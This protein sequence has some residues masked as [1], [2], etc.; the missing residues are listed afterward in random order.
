M[1]N[2]LFNICHILY[3]NYLKEQSFKLYFIHVR[4][5]ARTEVFHRFRGCIYSY[6]VIVAMSSSRAFDTIDHPIEQQGVDSQPVQNGTASV[7]F[8]VDST[9]QSVH[10]QNLT[11]QPLQDSGTTTTF[12]RDTHSPGNDGNHPKEDA[13]KSSKSADV[14][15]I[16]K[17]IIVTGFGGITRGESNLS[18]DVMREFFQLTN[19]QMTYKS[20][21]IP[22][23]TGY[24]EMMR[25]CDNLQP[26]ETS[27]KFVTTPPFDPWLKSTDAR[28]AVHLGTKEAAEGREIWFELQ[29]CNGGVNFWRADDYGTP[30]YG[31]ECIPGGCQ[32]LQTSFDIPTLIEKAKERVS[33]T[34]SIS[35][36][37]FSFKES[38][39][40]GKFLCDFLYYRSLYYATQRASSDGARNAIFIH[41]PPVYNLSSDI[42]TPA[43]LKQEI[44]NFA[45]VLEQIVFCLLDM[46]SSENEGET[47]PPPPRG[48][49]SSENGAN[50]EKLASGVESQ[51]E[52]GRCVCKDALALPQNGCCHKQVL[53]DQPPCSAN[54][55]NDLKN[56]Q[57]VISHP[58]KQTETLIE[59]SIV[60]TGFDPIY[61]KIPNQSWTIVQK[62]CSLFQQKD[63][64]VE[65]NSI[66]FQI[67]TGPPDRPNQPT[68]TTYD[69]VTSHDFNDWLKS[70]S[71]LL[72]I[73]VGVDDNLNGQLGNVF[74]F[75][76]AAANGGAGYWIEDK[77][78]Y[79]YPGPCMEDGSDTLCTQFGDKQI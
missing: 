75:E 53:S 32:Y 54:Q 16:V 39:D 74:S 47:T 64:K 58:L 11:S 43:K 24:P 51:D 4:D 36:A 45:F 17:P 73:H 7:P 72:Y 19:G 76:K 42:T 9:E 71:A 37:N 61:G 10:W 31:K 60:I 20:E 8:T 56:L 65:H 14:S 67:M 70:S 35:G 79:R 68:T 25:D 21:Q 34:T 12:I 13:L 69:Y 78:W 15:D 3:G 29:A 55:V 22:I 1:N 33:N 27:Y 44:K 57:E 66:P 38:T 40:A 18:A 26:V 59:N 5:S 63:G 77:N 50:D 62:F 23:L 41:I 52:G 28:L 2:L 49:M 46:C 48:I 6:T 30:C